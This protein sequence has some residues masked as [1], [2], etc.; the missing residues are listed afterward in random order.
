MSSLISTGS[1]GLKITHLADGSAT[2]VL[3]CSVSLNFSAK[4]IAVFKEQITDVAVGQVLNPY[5][6]VF[7]ADEMQRLMRLGIASV[8]ER[9]LSAS[10]VQTISHFEGAQ[11]QQVHFELGEDSALVPTLVVDVEADLSAD[12]AALRAIERVQQWIRS[13]PKH[14]PRE[15]VVE[16]LLLAD[17]AQ[18]PLMRA[19]L[20]WVRNCN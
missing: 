10:C 4:N 3:V 17:P 20:G 8:L 12:E 9:T 6:D 13:L 15:W 1:Q 14:P 2:G 19:G 11:T 16:E 5:Q 18:T 7:L